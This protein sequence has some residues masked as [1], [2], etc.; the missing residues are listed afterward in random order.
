VKYAIAA[1]QNSEDPLPPGTRGGVRFKHNFPAD[2]EYRINILDLSVGLYT[3]QMENE[4]TLVIMIDGKI[5]FRKAVGGPADQALADRHA[6]D[7]R[8]KIMD[9]FTKIPVEV[10]AG[11]RDVVVAFIER[12]EVESDENVGT[13]AVIGAFGA[14]GPFANRMPRLVDGIEI[15]GPFNPTGISKTSSRDLIFVC[16][17]KKAGE[18]AC[19]K[20]ITENLARRA[21]R[22]PVT[23]DSGRRVCS[24][25]SRTGF[26]S[27]FLPVEYAS[28]RGTAEGC[29]GRRV[30]QTWSAR[31]AGQA[32]DGRSQGLQPGH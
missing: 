22:R 17:P 24:H 23:A 7:G 29:R 16:D 11:V 3:A 15:V 18:P 5:V 20:Q 12:S 27:F 2:G 30:G 21:F 9:R 14:G 26:P 6:A 32:H 13:S 4:S 25:R 1:N 8:A 10:Q 31:C 19:A 28:G